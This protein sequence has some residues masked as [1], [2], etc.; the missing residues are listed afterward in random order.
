MFVSISGKYKE[1]IFMTE[2]LERAFTE[3]SKLPPEEQNILAEWL[4]AELSSE[5]RWSQLFANS[6]DVWLRLAKKPLMNIGKE[7]ARIKSGED[8]NSKTTSS[9]R[10]FLATLPHQIR[11]NARET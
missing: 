2:Q 3:A 8:L 10:D 11:Q 7:N 9:F 5:K 1:E 4:L 6:Q